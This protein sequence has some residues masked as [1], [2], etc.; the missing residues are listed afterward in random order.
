MS[1]RI[2][3]KKTAIFLLLL[4]AWFWR[5]SALALPSDNEFRNALTTC[6]AGANTR[7]SADLIGSINDIYEG[8][9]DKIQGKADLEIQSQFLQSLPDNMK[10]EGYRLYVEC[11]QKLLS[12]SDDGVKKREEVEAFVSNFRDSTPLKKIV[13]VFGEP[14]GEIDNF[15]DEDAK[16]SQLGKAKKF[17]AFEAAGVRLFVFLDGSAKYLA[18]GIVADEDESSPPQ[19]AGPITYLGSFNDITLPDTISQMDTSSAALLRID[20]RFGYFPV[21]PAYYGRPGGYKNF[22]FLFNVFELNDDDGNT[23]KGCPADVFGDVKITDFNCDRAKSMHPFM[24]VI[25]NED[26]SD[27][28]LIEFAASYYIWG[29]K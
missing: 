18:Y 4:F 21:G 6:A 3:V 23:Q 26:I 14:V 11:V 15:D 28:S 22:D 17:D 13:E 29:E 5:I 27:F 19:I 16:G 7:F 12:G 2:H 9:K 24:V 1:N 8:N 10:M 25:S 20:A